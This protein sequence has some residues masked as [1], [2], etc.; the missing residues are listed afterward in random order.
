LRPAR[1][2][3]DREALLALALLAG[4]VTGLGELA[5]ITGDLLFSDF[6]ARS[7]DAIW[8]IPA[9]DGALFVAVGLVLLLLRRWMQVPWWVAAGLFAG[10]GALLVLLLIQRLHPLAAV[11]VA[12]GVGTQASRWV[13]PRVPASVQ[14]VRRGL[15][16]LVGA[17]LLTAGASLAWRVVT[18]R[19]LAASR[20][21]PAPGSPSV[22]LLI[23]DTVRAAE[24][25]LYGYG[26]STTPELDR[27]AERGTVFERAFS[28]SSWTLP[29]HAAIFTGKPELHLDAT[30]WNHLGTDWPTLA[31]VLRGRGYG[32]VAFVA[33][34]DWAGW[35]SGLGRGFERYDDYPVSLWT[36]ISATSLGRVI[37][38]MLYD[39]LSGRVQRLPG[40]L[41]LRHPAQHRSAAA[42]AAGFL[43]WLDDRPRAP[44]FAFLNFMDAHT[45]YTPPDSFRSRYRTPMPRPASRYAYADRPPVRLTPTDMRPRQD[46]YDGSIAYLDTE[47]G[48]LFRALEARGALEN[49]L[50]VLTADHGEEF[51]EHGLGGHGS[52]LYR[53]SVQVPLV[54]WFPGHVPAGRR[55]TTPVSQHNLA[56]TVLD[57]AGRGPGRLPGR[58]LTRFWRSPDQARPDTILAT[59]LLPDGRLG[60][61]AFDGRRYIRDE[62]TGAEELYDFEHDVLERW[63]LSASDSGRRILPAYRAA[64]P[65]PDPA[66]A[67][68]TQRNP[69]HGRSGAAAP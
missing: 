16:W 35:D 39:G 18:E 37:Y 6:V 32:T 26:R 23:L 63:S 42:I 20:P 47:L 21:Q 30:H 12:A 17:V 59:L 8:M 2:S 24:L 28:S 22:L 62:V 11:A 60:S 33:N 4:I 66:R 64:L 29:S 10:L 14:A 3:F 31:E 68:L 49:T 40:R 51:A 7:R 69:L 58:S 54:L 48:R 43:G 52:T 15:P 36:A 61:I 50:V 44:Y 46:L 1:N 55:V 25:S 56:A 41:R 5:K 57:L 53:V 19:R 13:R 9:V 34:A 67:A 38:P 27:W 45:P 65:R